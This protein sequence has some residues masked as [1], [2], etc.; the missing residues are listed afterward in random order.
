M[1]LYLLPALS[2]C[3]LSMHCKV[4]CCNQWPKHSHNSH[5]FGLSSVCAVSLML[6]IWFYT[7]RDSRNECCGW[8]T[9]PD[10]SYRVAFTLIA[11]LNIS[12]IWLFYHL[13]AGRRW[14]GVG[15]NLSVWHSVVTLD[16]QEQGLSAGA[17]CLLKYAGIRPATLPEN[18]KASHRRRN[19]SNGTQHQNYLS[20]YNTIEGGGVA[21][22]ELRRK[23]REY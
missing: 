11:F 4:H 19:P 9:D 18:V 7:D 21:L 15:E 23:C 12:L 6:W 22:E 16:E 10:L 2:S 14:F 20:S 13:P 3:R 8:S 17:V 5:I 1:L